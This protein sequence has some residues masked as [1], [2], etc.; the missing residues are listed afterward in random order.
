MNMLLQKKN[1]AFPINTQKVM[2]ILNIGQEN[3]I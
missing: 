1:R 2:N 3:L